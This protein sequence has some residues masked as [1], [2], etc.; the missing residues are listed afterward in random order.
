MK[1][2]NIDFPAKK[3]EVIS[4][5]TDNEAVN[6]NV[7]FEEGKGKPFMKVK[8]KNNDKIRMTC[9]MLG[10]ATRDNGFL[11]GTYFAGRLVEKSDKTVLK[12]VILTAPIY[13]LFMMILVVVFILQCFYLKGFSVIPILL[14]GFDIFM[15][16]D[17]FKKQGYIKRYLHR[18]ARRIWDKASLT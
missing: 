6:K 18:A 10:K 15:F 1:F 2:I 9:E 13:H 14:V 8:I 4:M 16:K 3:D 11:V 5:I 12:G 17:E 7:R